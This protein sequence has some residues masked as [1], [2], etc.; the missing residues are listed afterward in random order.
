M[1]M[2]QMAAIHVVEVVDYTD[3]TKEQIELEQ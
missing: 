3:K 2:L 1:M